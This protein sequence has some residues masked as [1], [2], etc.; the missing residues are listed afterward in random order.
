VVCVDLRY[1]SSAVPGL[2]SHGKSHIASKVMTMVTTLLIATRSVK[3][4]DG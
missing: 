4:L 3:C 2:T 1:D